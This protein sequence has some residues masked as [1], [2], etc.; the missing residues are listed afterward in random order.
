MRGKHI[1]VGICGSIAA[2][3]AAVL[4]RDLIR[5]GAEV[6]VIMTTAACTFIT[7]LTL[8]TLSKNPVLHTLVKSED[9]T[10]NNHVD[11]A[12]WADLLVVAPAT[13]NTLSKFAHGACDDLLTAVYLSAKCQVFLA[14]AMDLDMWAH[15]ATR[16]NINLLKSYGN[17]II[18][19]DSGELASGLEGEG[20]L[21]EPAAITGI[22]KAW[23]A[24]NNS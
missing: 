9:G 17:Q 11:I 21:A 12:I 3:K 23:F 8:A 2:Y 14:P 4:V 6:R 7:P 5:E 18:Q 16:A 10:W 22:V 20:R 15:P 24:N 19:P 1:V 13:A